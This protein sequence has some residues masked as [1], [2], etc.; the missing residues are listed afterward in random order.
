MN[1]KKF[2]LKGLLML[3]IV[4]ALCMFF[5]RTVQTITTPK[6]QRISATKGKLE[7]K[8]SLY[9]EI[10]FPE[11]QD[12]KIE[13]A[14]KLS[15]TVEEVMVRPGYYVK[16]GDPIY[17]FY[18]P[19]YETK[20]K[21]IK[22]KYDE[23]VAEYADTIADNLRMKQSSGQNDLYTDMLDKI[24]QFYAVR[25][26][27]IACAAAENYTLPEDETLW[28]DITDGS[29]NLNALSASFKEKDTARNETVKALTNVYL[30]NSRVARIGDSTF[31]YIKNKEKLEKEIDALSAELIAFEELHQSLLTICAPHDGYITAA[32]LKVGDSYDGSKSAYTMTT[33]EAAPVLRVDVTNVDKTLREKLKVVLTD[34]DTES[35][36]ASLETTAEGKKYVYVALSSKVLKDAGGLSHLTSAEAIPLTI[37]YKAQKSTTLLPASAVRSDGSG[38]YYVY[39]VQQNY[40]GG[41]LGSGG[42]TLSKTPVTVIELSDQLV[43][44]EDDLS[45]REIADREDRALSDGQAVMDYV[46]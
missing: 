11:T 33:A 6:I 23:K 42:Y 40:G 27:L 18:A 24:N 10:Y 14:R 45:Y 26:D 37:T 32:E 4:I 16:S 9:G 30:G 35:E 43:A 22:D 7:Q 46:D 44:V 36:I 2:A 28:G 15:V 38:Q 20:Y 25:Y 39:V 21:E 17:R 12:I 41:L 13:N 8:I 34:T 5:S 19:D 3:F 29:E 31:E 1:K